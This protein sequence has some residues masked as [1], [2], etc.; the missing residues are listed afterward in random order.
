VLFTGVGIL[1]LVVFA[2]FFR[3]R[4]LEYEHK[5]M[6]RLIGESMDFSEDIQGDLTPELY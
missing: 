4:Y 3:T 2:C 1:G 6:K 5:L